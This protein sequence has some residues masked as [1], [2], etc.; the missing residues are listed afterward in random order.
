ME[1]GEQ[2]ERAVEAYDVMAKELAPA[3]GVSQ[4]Y[5][6]ALRNSDNLDPRVSNAHAL[7]RPSASL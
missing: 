1:C 3:S 4:C 7:S 6:N 5:I 2:L